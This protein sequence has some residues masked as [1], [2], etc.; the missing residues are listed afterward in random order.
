MKTMTS[1]KK[2][3]SKVRKC[4]EWIFFSLFGVLFVTV[5]T[6]QIIGLAT[7]K[8]NYGV[9]RFGNL[10][11][12]LVLTDSMEPDY[13]VNTLL[14]VTKVDVSTLKVGN[15]VTFYYKPWSDMFANPIV[16]HRIRDIQVNENVEYGKGKYTITLG[17]IN[18]NS[19]NARDISG[20]ETGDCLT[21]KQV[22]SEQ[23]ILGK[24]TGSSQFLGGVFN[25]VSSI[26]GL[27][28][29]LIIPALYIMITSGIDLVRAFKESDND[30]KTPADFGSLSIEDKERLKKQMI[31]E[32]MKERKN[33]KD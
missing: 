27:L 22:V 20:G 1:E 33:E 29:L 17:G 16:T 31:E 30:E 6:F 3:K 19:K 5:L 14:F 10:Q 13:K 24:V 26:W 12:N 15:D 8:N 7:K 9:P 25:F 28:I 11:L 18:R 2:P 4:L 21:Q 32:M 23:Y